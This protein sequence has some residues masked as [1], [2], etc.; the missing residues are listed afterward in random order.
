MGDIGL[1]LFDECSA[2]SLHL[3]PQ[4]ENRITSSWRDRGR[5]DTPSSVSNL[6]RT[7]TEIKNGAIAEGRIL[8]EQV[9]M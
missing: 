2:K 6:Q 9:I 1:N 4:E 3:S 8:V 5:M 7:L